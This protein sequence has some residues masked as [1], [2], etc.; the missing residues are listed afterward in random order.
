MKHSFGVFKK[1]LGNF[2][3]LGFLIGNRVY[4]V[5]GKF[6][7]LRPRKSH[8]NGGMGRNNKLRSGFHKSVNL[9]NKSEQAHGRKGGFRLVEEIQGYIV[10][11]VIRLGEIC[12]NTSNSDLSVFPS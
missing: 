12:L 1:I 7:N 9:G 6:K 8:Q 5:G 4:S 11:F 2:K 3:M 10:P